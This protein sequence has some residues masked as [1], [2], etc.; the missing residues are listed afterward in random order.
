MLLQKLQKTLHTYGTP[1]FNFPILYHYNI[2]T[3]F[4]NLYFKRLHTLQPWFGLKLCLI[5]P[6][7]NIISKPTLIIFIS[8][9]TDFNFMF[10]LSSM[11]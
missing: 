5:M 9:Y 2:P 7:A 11:Y 1:C 10:N 8:I 4:Q 3:D 6:N